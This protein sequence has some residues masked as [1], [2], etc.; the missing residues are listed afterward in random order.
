MRVSPV[1][2]SMN[3][4]SGIVNEKAFPS[5][6]FLSTSGFARCGE[7]LTGSMEILM[8][9]TVVPPWSS[10]MLIV[11]ESLPWKLALGV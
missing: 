2:T 7:S 1:S 4:C 6:A 8:N 5:S 10:V 9:R 3:V 11:N